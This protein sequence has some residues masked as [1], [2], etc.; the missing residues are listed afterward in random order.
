MSPQKTKKLLLEQVRDT[1]I[2]ENFRRI[3]FILDDL[4]A[5]GVIGP[6]GPAGP[7]GPPGD[8]GL[9]QNT[10]TPPAGGGT[11]S[12]GNITLT[13][14]RAVKYTI[15]VYNTVENV[16]SYQEF[17]VLNIDDT[18]GGLLNASAF[19]FGASVNYTVT[20]EV[21][22]GQIELTVTNNEAYPLQVE[23]TQVLL[24]NLS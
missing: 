24:G 21:V 19:K 14:N 11:I 12:G 16:T 10:D 18:T 15:L 4:E 1:Y 23:I 13:Q 6:T 20:S 3:E 22:S 5:A 7:A 2:R 17:V 8:P 9:T